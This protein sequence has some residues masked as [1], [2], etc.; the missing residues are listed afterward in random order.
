MPHPTHTSRYSQAWHDAQDTEE[1][2]W[3]DAWM[4][5]R[6]DPTTLHPHERPTPAAPALAGRH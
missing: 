4:R 6:I 5:G 1:R 2:D 3:L